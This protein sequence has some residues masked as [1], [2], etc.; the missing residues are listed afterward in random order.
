[1][2]EPYKQ[3]LG[4]SIIFLPEEHQTLKYIEINLEMREGKFGQTALT[5]IS[6]TLI[7]D[8]GKEISTIAAKRIKIRGF[9]DDVDDILQWT[10]RELEI[11]IKNKIQNNNNAC[12]DR[13]NNHDKYAPYAPLNKLE[14]HVYSE[15]NGVNMI[16]GEFIDFLDNIYKIL[17]NKIITET[18]KNNKFIHIKYICPNSIH[19]HE[20]C[21][22]FLY[23]FANPEFRKKFAAFSIV[24]QFKIEKNQYQ[25]LIDRHKF[26]DINIEYKDKENHV[27]H[28]NKTDKNGV[29]SSA[30]RLPYTSFHVAIAN[31]AEAIYEFANVNNHRNNH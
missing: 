22:Y 13:N 19:K 8:N 1:M 16:R 21:D 3:S 17:K 14:L 11:N 24:L 12:L 23:Q 4:Y 9:V 29:Y 26:F 25:S 6:R 27:M 15:N 10:N 30:V 20:C 18:K 28:Y 2:T 7:C 5:K 31:D